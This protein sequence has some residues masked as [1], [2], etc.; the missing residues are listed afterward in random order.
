MGAGSKFTGKKRKR[1]CGS[2]G[3][4]GGVCGVHFARFLSELLI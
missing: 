2:G 1:S 3:G 4:W